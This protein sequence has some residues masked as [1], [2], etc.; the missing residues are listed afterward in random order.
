MAFW[1][2]AVNKGKSA[3]QNVASGYGAGGGGSTSAPSG[4]GATP[5]HSALGGPGGFDA[6]KWSAQQAQTFGQDTS[7]LAHD[8]A[9]AAK[10]PTGEGGAQSQS[11]WDPT[12]GATYYDPSGGLVS[13][14]PHGASAGTSPFLLAGLAVM[15]YLLLK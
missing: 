10:S 5:Y 4:G 2:D 1:D 9:Q 11:P 15:A 6:T 12:A 8:I 7:T 14:P 13:V 3:A